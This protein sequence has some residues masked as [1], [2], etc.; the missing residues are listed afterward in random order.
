MTNGFP[1]IL[2]RP[3]TWRSTWESETSPIIKPTY[4]KCKLYIHFFILKNWHPCRS[5]T[6]FTSWIHYISSQ[7]QK[8]QAPRR[9]DMHTWISFCYLKR[10]HVLKA[11][12]HTR[13]NARDHYTSSTLIG[14]KGGPA[15]VR[16]T[17]RLRDQR[18]MWLQDGCK[19]YAVSY[20]TSNDSCFM[21]TWIIFKNH[22][23]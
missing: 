17:L 11:T 14:R 10:L 5:T 13:L 2:F 3:R 20:M 22:F 15:Q 12:S 7:L 6:T 4:P 19:V 9:L 8:Q 16:F 23:L 18:S 1:S 21:V